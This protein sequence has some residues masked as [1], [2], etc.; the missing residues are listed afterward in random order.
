[1]NRIRISTTR[2]VLVIIVVCGILISG[3]K[4]CGEQRKFAIKQAPTT[5]SGQATTIATLLEQNQA[6]SRQAE[7]GKLQA[8][9]KTIGITEKNSAPI[10]GIRNR[11]A[12]HKPVESRG[13]QLPPEVAALLQEQSHL[14]N[15]LWIIENN[16]RMAGSN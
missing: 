12:L 5:D 2:I 1:M 9:T 8:R 6:V 13:R 7:G 3:C 15:T 16:N 11:S 10:V 4:Q 14:Q